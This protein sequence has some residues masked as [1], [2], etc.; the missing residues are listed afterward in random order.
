MKLQMQIDLPNYIDKRRKSKMIIV[1]KING[2]NLGFEETLWKAADKLRSNLDASQ[3]KHVILG[4]IFLKYLSDIFNEKYIDLENKGKNPKNESQYS[5]A[6]IFWVPTKSRWNF[7]LTKK[8]KPEIGKIINNAIIAIEKE[9]TQ[10]KN[11]LPKIFSNPDLDQ[12]RL[13]ELIELIGSIELRGKQNHSRDI[14][15]R[16]YEYFLGQFANAE[17]KKG[18]QFYTPSSI[19]RLLVSMIEPYNGTVYD[20]C[21]GSGGM[22]VQSE[23]FVESHGGNKDDILIFGQESNPTTWRLGKMNLGIRRIN[24]D[25][26]KKPADSFQEDLHKHL[27]ADFILANPPFN[28][29]D[30]RTND[31]ANDKR[32]KFG[33]PP[34][35][36]ANFAW[37]QHFIHHLS[38]SGIAGFVLANGSLS[39]NIANEGEI[40]RKIIENDLVDCIISLP[41]Q[42]FY[43]T[44]IAACL[45]FIA[46][47]K[48]DK[49]YRTR[50]G[51]TLFIEAKNFGVL[52]D[53]THRELLQDEIQKISE[54][55]HSWKNKNPVKKYKNIIGFCQTA[56]IENI[57]NH[58]Y[59]LVPGRYTGCEPY[60]NMKIPSDTQKFYSQ[61]ISKRFSR[62]KEIEGMLLSSMGQ[63]S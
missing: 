20:P 55:Y 38:P 51:E 52:V 17:G 12:K 5:K 56:T 9:N 35:Q 2:T 58:K 22:F 41:T 60:K 14:L 33:I 13:G 23:K 7:L 54:T 4:L 59:V 39:S 45:W 30:W 28:S 36:N 47:D 3:Y 62:I 40:R 61:I 1:K 29:S 18:G 43:S 57:K 50:T 16:V 31:L 46:A 44:A 27:K 49:K 6:K 8:T 26:G 19:V 15:G 25:I 32:W 42:L 21:C 34:N 10:L 53:K 24:E 37:I 63:F 48:S 11:I